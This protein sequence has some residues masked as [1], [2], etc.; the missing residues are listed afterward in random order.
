MDIQLSD[1]NGEM[2]FENNDIFYDTLGNLKTVSDEDYLA[3]SILKILYTKIGQD[4][5][6]S[7]YGSM[8]LDF[9]AQKIDLETISDIRDSVDTALSYLKYTQSQNS[10]E[11]E[12]VYVIR[13]FLV[14]QNKT[15]PSSVKVYFEVVNEANE[16]N[17][18]SIGS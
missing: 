10:N 14:M 2:V 5:T 9:I 4:N 8:V 3:Q 7:L 6:D 15:Q 18:V 16:S 12:K 17:A 13:N 1:S 11:K